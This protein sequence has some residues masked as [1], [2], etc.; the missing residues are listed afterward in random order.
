MSRGNAPD[1]SVFDNLSEDQKEALCKYVYDIMLQKKFTSQEGYLVVDVFSE[2][3]K[4]MGVS[5]QSWRVAQSRFDN[6]LQSAPQYFRLFRKSIRISNPCGWFT[7][8]GQ[9]MMCLVLDGEKK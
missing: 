3:S 6:L 7:R 4:D 5:V 9:K 8:K 1:D 2:V